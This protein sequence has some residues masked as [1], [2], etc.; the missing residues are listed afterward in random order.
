[1]LAFANSGRDHY[2]SV[3]NYNHEM[4]E[5]QDDYVDTLSEGW[6]Q[7][8][9]NNRIDR[10]SSDL[11]KFMAMNFVSWYKENQNRSYHYA[12]SDTGEDRPQAMV[13]QLDIED[14]TI[15]TPNSEKTFLIYKLDLEHARTQRM[16]NTYSRNRARLTAETIE[17]AVYVSEMNKYTEEDGTVY[18]SKLPKNIIDHFGSCVDLTSLTLQPTIGSVGNQIRKRQSTYARTDKFAMW[19]GNSYNADVIGDISFADGNDIAQNDLTWKTLLSETPGSVSAIELTS[20]YRGGGGKVKYDKKQSRIS[21]LYNKKNIFLYAAHY[22][23]LNQ[24]NLTWEKAK[25][26]N[27]MVTVPI[28]QVF[29]YKRARDFF[30]QL[31]K[32]M[33]DRGGLMFTNPEQYYKMVREKF[34]RNMTYW[35]GLKEVFTDIESVDMEYQSFTSDENTVEDNHLKHLQYYT[36][37]SNNSNV[38]EYNQALEN[39]KSIEKTISQSRGTVAN[40]TNM[41]ESNESRIKQYEEYIV[42]FKEEIAKLT[43]EKEK[44]QKKVEGVEPALVELDKVI[45]ELE[46]QNDKTIESLLDDSTALEIPNFIE[47][48]AKSGIIIDDVTYVIPAMAHLIHDD[49]NKRTSEENFWNTGDGK[50][51]ED[52]FQEDAIISIKDDPR[53]A[54]M[55]RLK[56]SIYK[57]EDSEKIKFIESKAYDSGYTAVKDD[58][59]PKLYEVSFHTTKPVIIRV[60]YGQKGEDCKKVVGGPYR[61]KI[62]FGTPTRSSY[63]DNGWRVLSPAM[64]IAL[65][66]TDAC[67]GLDK[68]GSRYW[69]HPHANYSTYYTSNWEDFSK[70]YD[71]YGSAC[72]G[73]ASPTLYKAYEESDLKTA[74]FGAMGWV[75]SANSSDQWGRNYNKFPKLSQVN[76]DGELEEV[77]PEETTLTTEEGMENIAEDLANMIEENETLNLETT[78][79]SIPEP[80]IIEEPP[81]EEIQAIDTH[82]Y[83]DYLDAM[84]EAL[85]PVDPAELEVGEPSPTSEEQVENL[86]ENQELRSAGVP[87]YVSYATLT[88]NQ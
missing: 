74:I 18:Y 25:I 26:I 83:H 85:R 45:E 51:R 86:D 76:L 66:S 6:Q 77:D 31:F 61:V 34:G 3:R 80:E 46:K 14:W 59:I 56:R 67:F 75:T 43:A 32:N 64:Y 10:K 78:F 40:N 17:N 5:S 47:N 16:S 58:F 72:L 24:E 63:H 8:E 33:F 73:E 38:A 84:A 27:M 23:I 68:N 60:D 57:E 39:K 37:I 29:K 2:Y 21:H 11:N 53:I 55:A 4:P 81:V 48:L 87:N 52:A 13:E 35:D 12:W 9:V 19:K 1:M 62:A 44:A 82:N 88:N 28:E 41:I 79:I 65:A 71:Y 69:V 15:R 22:T 7:A 42:N 36:E 30:P 49:F 20:L 54:L 70:L 50:T